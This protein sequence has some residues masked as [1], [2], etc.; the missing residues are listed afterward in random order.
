MTHVSGQASVRIGA[1]ASAEGRPGPCVNRAKTGDL[2][3]LATA[4]TFAHTE[5]KIHHLY[6]SLQ[7]TRDVKQSGELRF[8]G[9]L[10]PNSV[11]AIESMNRSN[12]KHA[13]LWRLRWRTGWLFNNFF[14]IPF[15]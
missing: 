1:K 9:V 11:R 8:L 13:A 7:K 14:A 10:V 5:E 15:C 6:S 3:K 12:Y 4:S 2:T